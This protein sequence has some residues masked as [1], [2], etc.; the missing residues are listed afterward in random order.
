ME[1]SSQSDEDGIRYLVDARRH[2]RYK[3]DTAIWVHPH[4]S[5]VVRGRT[6][7]LSESGISAILREEVPL[8]EVVRLEFSLPHFGEVDIHALVRQHNAFRYGFQFVETSSAH[9]VIGL[10]CRQL[11]IEQASRD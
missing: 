1:P 2:P 3:L 6:V 4:D 10:M 8:G 9:D 5:R 7:D 11:A